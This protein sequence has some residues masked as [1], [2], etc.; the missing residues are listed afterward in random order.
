[1]SK[2]F[3]M[4]TLACL[5][6]GLLVAGLGGVSA[7]DDQPVFR[8]VSHGGIGNPFWIVVIK[9]MEEE[10]DRI[11][12]D[13]EWLSDP[14]DNIDDMA[15]YCDDALAANPDGL[16]ITVPNPEVIR[17]CVNRAAEAGIPVIVLNTAD[18]NA[19]T[20]DALPTMF[21][22]GANEFTGGVSNANR[23]LAAA[24][25]DGV[26][27]TGAVC[28]IQEVG[29]S[30][31]EARCAGVRSVL[32]EAGIPLHGLT[33]NND[34]PA[35][36]GT[37][38]D[39]FAANPDVNA[40]FMLGPNPSSSLNLCLQESGRMP[41]DIYATT[42]DTSAEIYEMIKDGYLLQAIDQQPYLQGSETIHW[43]YLNLLAGLAPG[44]DILTGPGVIDANNIAAVEEAT[45]EG[46]R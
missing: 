1:M 40:A 15:G 17:D 12:A 20:P 8:I 41:G 44:G 28:P 18:P 4:V 31:L 7:Q 33:I 23:V 16:G 5:V 43:L 38:C 9:G 45:A 30:G 2:S 11:G 39:F 34:V 42:H 35:S 37:L 36:A 14:V 25:A 32:E 6:V 13:C 3:R 26:E 19:G 10:C 27:I 46:R 21:Y 29:H 24:A 22:I